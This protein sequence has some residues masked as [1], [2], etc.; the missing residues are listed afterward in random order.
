ML[1][2]NYAAICPRALYLIVTKEHFSL[3]WR[4]EAGHQTQQCCLAATGCT[5]R[6]DEV[7][8]ID[9]QVD[10][11]QCMNSLSRSLARINDTDVFYVQI[12]HDLSLYSYQQQ[13]TGST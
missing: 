5:Q 3:R 2:K 11:V 7:T 10:I 6:H 8:A 9:R 12:F 4:N 1:L 13:R